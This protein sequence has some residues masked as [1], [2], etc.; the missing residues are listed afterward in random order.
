[1][2]ELSQPAGMNTLRL[3]LL[4]LAALVAIFLGWTYLHQPSNAPDA[5]STLARRTSP[6]EVAAMR[7][8]IERG[9]A[10]ATDYVGFFERLKTAFPAEY[11]GFLTRAAERAAAPGETPSAD[12]LMIEAARGL[13]SSHGILAAKAD[14]P[15]LDHYFEAKRAMLDALAA[16]DQVLCV[17]F[18]YGG[19]NGDFAAFSRDHRGLLAAM[20]NAGLDAINDGQAKRVERDAPNDADFHTLENALR[21]QGVSNAAIGALLDGKAP[22]PPLDDGEM[23]QAGQIFLQT[24]AALPDAARR[25]IYGFAVELMAHS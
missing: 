8:T 12:A 11:E 25:R 21:A 5:A 16:K 23:C 7:R 17:D 6:Q 13:R 24:L 19:G 9:I 22:N 18:L 3:A 15:A 20:A 1:M 10:G 2:D 4:S 14:G